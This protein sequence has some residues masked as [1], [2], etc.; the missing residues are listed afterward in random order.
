MGLA[1]PVGS[2]RRAPTIRFPLTAKIP[3]PAAVPEAADQALEVLAGAGSADREAVVLAEAVSAAA[4]SGDVAAPAGAEGLLPIATRLSAT[5]S[6]VAEQ[7][8]RLAEHQIP[9]RWITF[10][11]GHEIREEILNSEFI[12]Q[13]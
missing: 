9:C 13:N 1:D 4:V 7:Q 5:E 2:T 12:I 6:I 11:G 3:G 10:D 8:T